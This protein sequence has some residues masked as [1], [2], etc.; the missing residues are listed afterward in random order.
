MDLTVLDGWD[1]CGGSDPN[2]WLVEGGCL[3]YEG[4]C[5]LTVSLFMFSVYLFREF[6]GSQLKLCG[7]PCLCFM[8]FIS[9][10]SRSKQPKLSNFSLLMSQNRY[11]VIDHR[12][13]AVHLSVRLR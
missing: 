3:V 13:A 1:V 10:T 5:F 11:L 9:E 7:S 4:C 2:I 12:L 6:I 8:D